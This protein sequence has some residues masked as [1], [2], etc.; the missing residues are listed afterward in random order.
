LTRSRIATAFAALVL[1]LLPAASARCGEP[2]GTAAFGGYSFARLADVDRHGG[3]LAFDFGIAGPLAAFVDTSLHHGSDGAMAQDD[4]TLMAGPGVR[5]GRRGGL[6][7]FVRGVAG[8]VRDRASV[9]VLDVT[10]SESASRFGFLAGGGVDVHVA[11]RWALRAQG[12]YLWQDDPQGNASGFRVAAGVVCR[13]G[14]K[15]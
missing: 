12:D 9:D 6:V 2:I 11:G 7:F 13:F 15:P 14:A 4:L 1:S 8:L 5:F 3:S 10:I